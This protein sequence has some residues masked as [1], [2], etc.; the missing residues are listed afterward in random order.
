MFLFASNRSPFFSPPVHELQKRY[1]KATHL[2]CLSHVLNN[3]GRAALDAEGFQDV[4]D[5]W[6]ASRKFLNAK[7]HSARRCRWFWFLK[8]NQK[9]LSIP[10]RSLQFGF[11]SHGLTFSGGARQGGLAGL[12]AHSGGWTTMRFSVHLFWFL[13]FIPI[14]S[15]F[16]FLPRQRKPHA[17]RKYQ[18]H[19]WNWPSTCHVA[20]V[21]CLC[22]WHS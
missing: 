8:R 7:T 6:T 22:A 9:S 15:T 17:R 18:Q 12:I 2:V 20:G 21:L 1:P 10:P 11:S 14:F 3:I 19:F 16:L 4:Q 13:C 5:I